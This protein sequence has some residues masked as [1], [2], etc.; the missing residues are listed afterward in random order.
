MD[1]KRSHPLY[2]KQTESEREGVL[3][4]ERTTEK[5]ML[6]EKKKKKKEKPD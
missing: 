5:K 4:K 6:I 3:E 2:G 1:W